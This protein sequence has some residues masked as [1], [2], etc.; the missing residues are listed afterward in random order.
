M[1]CQFSTDYCCLPPHTSKLAITQQCCLKEKKKMDHSTRL[2]KGKADAFKLELPGDKEVKT[3]FLDKMQRVRSLLVNKLQR[4]VNNKIILET[5]ID[6]W[7]EAQKT[8]SSKSV[9]TVNTYL[10]LQKEHTEQDLYIITKSSMAK[11]LEVIEKHGQACKSPLVLRRVQRSGHVA[12][13]KL[14]CSHKPAHAYTWSTSP[15]LPNSRFLANER[16]QHA[17]ATS[18]MLPVHYQ[19]FCAGAHIGCVSKIVSR[20]FFQTYKNAIKEEH[21]ESVETALM[22]EYGHYEFDDKWRGISIITDARHGWRKNAK[23]TSVVTIG[24]RSH[25]VLLHTHVTKL[26]DHCTQRHERLGTE[27][28]YKYFEDEGVE[29]GVHSH[30]R[31]MSINKLVK[32]TPFTTNQNDTWHSIRT[33]KKTVAKMG[34]GAKYLKGKTW[35]PQLED[36]DEAVAR[37]CHWAIQHCQQDAAQLRESLLN[38]VEHYKGNHSKCFASSRCQK[39]PKYESSKK[40][41]S[42]SVA[43]SMLKNAILKSVLYTSAPDFILGKSTYHVESFNNVMNIFHDKR[44]AFGD[45]QYLARSHLAVCHWNENCDRQYT[46][47][48]MPKHDP[49]APRRRKGKKNYRPCTY[50]YRSSIWKRYVQSL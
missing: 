4:P 23:D 48:W 18:G 35:H 49:K 21:D 28:V 8:P 22:V 25:Q 19:R 39:D 45:E 13:C 7:L 30:D 1:A 2:K 26:D 6:H 43:E 44:I 10:K 42:E 9:P 24:E 27:K 37:H 29:V 40:I 16:M 32:S 36:K 41:I 12:I 17:M 34:F 46:S 14:S 33:L 3:E 20:D 50:S 11:Y 15:Y 38:V 47:T 5:V 31:N